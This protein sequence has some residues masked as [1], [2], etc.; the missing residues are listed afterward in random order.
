MIGHAE[1]SLIEVIYTSTMLSRSIDNIIGDFE[2]QIMRL[3][4]DCAA[5]N[6]S[7]LDVAVASTATERRSIER[8]LSIALQIQNEVGFI[9]TAK[10]WLDEVLAQMNNP[11]LA[12]DANGVILLR[13]AAAQRA[14]WNTERLAELAGGAAQAKAIHKAADAIEPT[15]EISAVPIKLMM[16][17]KG[18]KAAVVKR[19][20]AKAQAA[21]GRPIWLLILAD[22][23]ID[24]T[25]A[26]QAR[27]VFGLT[28]AESSVALRFVQGASLSEISHERGVSLETV[29]AQIRSIK[30]KTGA[31]DLYVLVRILCALAHGIY[32]PTPSLPQTGQSKAEA[33]WTDTMRLPD[34]RRL[35]FLR[36]G[37]ANGVPVMLLHTLAYGAQLPLAA[38]E[39]AFAHGL[40]II[41]PLRAGHGYSDAAPPGGIHAL[42]AQST[43]D[44]LALMDHL[45]YTKAHLLGHSAGAT[46]AIHFAHRHPHR[47]QSVVMTNWGPI[48]RNQWLSELQRNH[49]A[50]AIAQQHFPIAARLIA[51]A[52]VQHFHK[53]GAKDYAAA[54]VQDSEADLAVLAA[55]ELLH[56]IGN[57]VTFGLR[58]GPDIYC[59]E[60]ELM[61]VDLTEEARALP[62]PLTLIYGAQDR[63]VAPIFPQR[64]AK[65]VPQ[66]RLIE[67]PD[68]GHY[69]FYSHWRAVLEAIT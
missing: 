54:A 68:A 41:A 7:I 39:Y 19:A 50:M 20:G 55:P 67:M 31:R 52:I 65:A 28:K 56:L 46:H 34:G 17:G 59:R 47:T 6:A 44:L 13:N 14:H 21:W 12:F 30:V 9:P 8:H 60:F 48:W 63:V 5:D 35:D 36:H 37:D 22:F 29:R 49:R 69:L 53:H 61:Q 32:T 57:G 23:A 58:Q 2:A 62:H 43:N 10:Q 40:N 64:F 27:T 45:G 1:S 24:A 15:D 3:L 38:H 26:Q 16:M 18:N 4:D 11:A 51:G 25:L 66:T 33:P 42:L